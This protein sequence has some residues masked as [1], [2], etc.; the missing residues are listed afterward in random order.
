MKRLTFLIGIIAMMAMISCC[1]RGG[2]ATEPVAA[3][4]A[5]PE[6]DASVVV[7]LAHPDMTRSRMNTVL[8]AAAAEVKGVQ[9]INIYDYPLA[10][11]TY[12]EVITRAKAIVY[13]FPFYWMSSPHLLKQWTDEVFMAFV[14][15][16]LIAGKEFMVVTTTGSEEAAYQHDGRNKYTMEEYLRPFEGQA[17]HAKMQWNTPLV[18]YGDRD[19]ETLAANLKRGAEEYEARLRMLVEKSN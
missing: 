18:V 5:I 3:D 12:R 19:A 9:V 11:D 8:A 1:P 17:N 16:G 6:T 2:T 7:L 13:E 10:A 4:P 15:E 14:G